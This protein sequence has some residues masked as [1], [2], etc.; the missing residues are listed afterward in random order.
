[1]KQ[2]SMLTALV[3]RGQAA[4]QASEPK[5]GEGRHSEPFSQVLR[6]AHQSKSTPVKAERP[7]SSIPPKSAQEPAPKPDITMTAKQQNS[8]TATSTA[9]QRESEVVQRQSALG[10]AAREQLKQQLLS[11]Q[12][13]LQQGE[14]DPQAA[15]EKLKTLLQDSELTLTEGMQSLEQMLADVA[16]LAEQKQSLI[17][18]LEAFRQGLTNAEQ[19]SLA[20]G[21]VEEGQTE[22]NQVDEW[23]LTAMPPPSQN[24]QRKGSRTSGEATESLSRNNRSSI[25]EPLRT[26][27]KGTEEAQSQPQTPTGTSFSSVLAADEE[28]SVAGSPML[29][30]GLGELKQLALGEGELRLNPLGN[31]TLFSQIVESDKNTAL[32]SAMPPANAQVAAPVPTERGFTIQTMVNTLVG[33]PNWG[34]AVGQRVMWLTQQNI[35]E[36]QLRLD[37]PD[38]GP[39]KVKISVQNDQAQVVFTSHSASVREALD[40]SL[41]RLRELFAEQGLD[42]VN[43]DVSDH[44][45]QQENEEQASS[46]GTSQGQGGGEPDA[47]EASQWV[48]EGQLTLVDHYA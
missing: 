20:D 21:Q 1:M 47:A 8:T 28:I 22:D 2:T 24:A 5:A 48:M 14:I 30:E 39:I 31:K 17:A 19:Q 23:A 25:D 32:A 18:W 15:L 11:L 29:K 36:A 6:S 3:A 33:Q 34:Q 4:S 10:T 42:L 44:Q 37:P 46:S 27:S 9:L 41:Q 7:Q 40:Q 38:L 13:A 35:T 16:Q 26:S 43:V 12:E 45:Q